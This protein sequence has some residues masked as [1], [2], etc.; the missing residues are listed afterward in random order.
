MENVISTRV[1][2]AS[3]SLNTFLNPNTE[4][5]L[6]KI[7]ERMG[8]D[9]SEFG[10]QTLEADT[11]TFEDFK[12]AVDWVIEDSY[13]IP[14]PSIPIP[15]L[16]LAW[17]ILKPSKKEEPSQVN[18]VIQQFNKPV[19]QWSDLEVLEAYNK[20]CPIVIEEELK[21]RSKDNFCIIFNDDETVDVENSLYLLRKAKRQITPS[22]FSI[23]GEIKKVYRISEFPMSA[24]YECPIHKDVLLMDGYCEECATKWDMTDTDR[25]TFLRLITEMEPSSDYRSYK[26]LSFEELKEEFPKVFLKFKELKELD[27]LP[28]MKRELSSSE[29]GD[30][31]RVVGS[32]HKSF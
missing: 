2:E 1:E 18:N 3:K 16:K 7:L 5:Q 25:I 20:D 19:G 8:I 30:P 14:I 15:R 12:S 21:K 24:F 26:K 28:N 9:D 6:L 22:T 17:N 10:L 13:S 31:F 23:R 4:K 29:K 32:S 11:T 27:H